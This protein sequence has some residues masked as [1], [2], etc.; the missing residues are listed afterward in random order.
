MDFDVIVI[1]SGFGGAI[2]SCRLAEKNYKVLMLERGRRWDRFTYPRGPDDPWIWNHECPETESGWL[3]LRSFKHMAVAQG[4]GV[5]GGSLIYANISCEPRPDI[6]NRGW[7]K[8]ITYAELKPHYDR[9]AD[10][11]AVQPV[12]DNQWPTRTKLMKE[13]AEAIGEGSR[14][15]QLNLAVS[16]DPAW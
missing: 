15:A 16:F 8:E 10:F 2:T 13:A 6:F 4:A 9:V 1:G 3:D 12:P 14:F 7:P 11:M 5:G